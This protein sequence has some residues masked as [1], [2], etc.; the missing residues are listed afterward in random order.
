M[1]PSLDMPTLPFL[2][3]FSWASVP[4]DPVNILA[5]FAAVALAVPEI[6]VIA[7]WGWGPGVVNP[8][9]GEREAVGGRGWHH[10]TERL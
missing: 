10:S 8:N 3:N 9:L 1:G 6:I 2:Q 5:T 4:M 7:V